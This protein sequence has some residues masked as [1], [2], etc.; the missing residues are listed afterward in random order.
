M[1]GGIL[2]GIARHAFS[3]GPIELVPSVRVTR[4]GGLDG[5]F[6]GSL[7]PG[8]N[9]RQVSLM[10]VGDWAQAMTL[11]GHDLPWWERRANLL[12]EGFDLPQTPGAR[13]RVGGVLLEITKEC[14]PCSRMETIAEGLRAAL[15]P[16][17]RGGALAQVV[18]GGTIAVGDA[19][20]LEQPR[21]GSARER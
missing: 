7:K 6:R 9:K 4:E 16:D 11:I 15:T 8:R 20:E 14:D 13:I 10:E 1:A 12:V 21:Q 17:W 19:I 18:E 2:K 3:R 5:D